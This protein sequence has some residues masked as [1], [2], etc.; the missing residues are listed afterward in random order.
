MFFACETV[1]LP[2]PC[3][4]V[5]LANDKKIDRHIFRLLQNRPEVSGRSHR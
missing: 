5:Y 2:S 4:T 3:K 1:V